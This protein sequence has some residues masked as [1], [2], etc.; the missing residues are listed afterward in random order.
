M[1][2][3]QEIYI[4]QCASSDL[5]YCNKLPPEYITIHYWGHTEWTE[6]SECSLKEVVSLTITFQTVS[7]AATDKVE[8]LKT[9]HHPL[10]IK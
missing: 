4:W 10:Q 2:F 8:R 1:T 3:H 7:A 9:C 5:M 6:K